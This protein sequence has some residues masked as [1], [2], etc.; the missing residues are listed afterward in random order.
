MNKNLGTIDRI[1]RTIAGLTVGVLILTGTLT[2]SVAVTLGVL[3]VVLLLTGV[4]SFCPLYALL[5]LSSRT[6]EVSK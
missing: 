6:K 1:A 5:N 4:V 3:A 2:G